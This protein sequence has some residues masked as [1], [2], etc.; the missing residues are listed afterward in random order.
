ML[1]A[2]RPTAAMI[3]EIS[4]AAV[5]ASAMRLEISLV[6]ALCCSTAAAIAV[7]GFG[8]R[9]AILDGNVKRVF[10]RLFAIDGFPGEAAVA[11]RLWAH[12]NAEL[13]PIGTSAAALGRYT[14]G[15]MDLGATC[16]A[17]TGPDCGRCPLS[18]K[19][20]ARLRAEISR[21][22]AARPRRAV[23]E[24][25]A[26]LLLIRRN[27]AVLLEERPPSGIWGGLW[28]LP[29]VSLD[30]AGRPA[31]LPYGLDP[32]ALRTHGGFD[33]AFTHFRMRATIWSTAADP[34]PFGAAPV[35][36]EGRARPARWLAL[37]DV[38]TAPLPQPIK[39][40]LTELQEQALESS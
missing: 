23:P 26:H 2:L 12:A 24:R 18:A 25:P 31:D 15:L 39:R 3:S 10:S 30:A 14:Q 22:P 7:F 33:H 27:G 28:S 9:A 4:P 29:E 1:W 21:F 13:P 8:V 16:C 17:R 38:A 5:P 20:G 35:D 40:L 6:A 37:A 11:R 19:C 34:V 36:A 32:A